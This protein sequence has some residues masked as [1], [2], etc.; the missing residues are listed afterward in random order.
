MKVNKGNVYSSVEGYTENEYIRLKKSLSFRVPNY[1][2]MTAYKR[3]GWD[4]FMC[5]LNSFTK[6]FP[7]GLIEMLPADLQAGMVIN[8]IRN[9]PLLG[10]QTGDI[11]LRGVELRDY[12][13][14]AVRACVA[15]ERAILTSPTNAGKS[16]PL[17]S[18]VFTPT[19]PKLMGDIKEGDD[20][21]TPDG[22]AAKVISI[23]PQGKL[24]VYRITFTNGDSVECSADH[25]WKVGSRVN[26][27]KEKVIPLKDIS[28]IFKN[29]LGRNTI[30]I[31]PAKNAV[32]FERRNV[33]I[34]PYLLGVLLG[35]GRLNNRVVGVSSVDG[36]ILE[37]VKS[38]L[39]PS[40]SLKPCGTGGRIDH[41]I[42]G[43]RGNKENFYIKTL[44]SYGLFDVRSHEKFIP[45]DYKYNSVDVRYAILNGLMDTDG[46][47]GKRYP[48]RGVEFCSTSKQLALDIKEIVESLGGVCRVRSRITKFTYRGIK[49][50]GKRSYTITFGGKVAARAFTLKRKLDRVS[51]GE[52]HQSWVISK[53]EPIGE[54]ECRCILVDSPDHLYLTDHCIPTHNTEMGAAIL[55]TLP[56]KA[57]WLTHRGDLLMQTRERLENRLGEPVG[58]IQ[59]ENVDLQPITIGMVQSLTVKIGK[60]CEDQEFFVDFLR[61]IDVLIIDECHHAGSGS[62]WKDIVKKCPAYYRFGLSATP[63]LRE[64]IENLWLIG[65]TGM[66]VKTVTNSDLVEQGIS[67][68]PKIRIVKN[69]VERHSIPGDYHGSY[70]QAIVNNP[71]RNACIARLAERHAA[72]KEP[73][74]ILVNTIEHGLNISSVLSCNYSF[75]TG[76]ETLEFRAETLKKMKAGKLP[77]II[78]TPI[79]DEGID[80][81]SIRVLILAAGG[82]SE[83]RMLQRVGRGMRKKKSGL[84]EVVI[85]DFEDAGDRYLRAHAVNREEICQREGFEIERIE[86]LKVGE[87]EAV[88]NGL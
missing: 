35:D 65:L 69:D 20:V 41:Y 34:D 66:E 25:L 1:W 60:E 49:K 82:K 29:K 58:V 84:N 51:V 8:D 40:Y 55:K 28:L 15:Q 14:E 59:G 68:K 85:Y 18:L 76:K 9:K 88:T 83:I 54:K 26:W 10:P 12:Q 30:Q 75:L 79:F 33:R 37:K 63:L 17:D 53:I 46:F 16:Q 81:P 6:A 23:F 5:F 2:F 13:I 67:A 42:S 7:T 22:K 74:L 43:E 73:V 44:S 78:A 61:S 80:A 19:G 70:D 77:V 32:L 56:F 27:G 64:Q 52:K 45:A 86:P 36:E 3:G 38:V 39:I 87:N 24:L 62:T 31:Y 47:A 48:R 4:G 11:K 21:S 72:A 57:L 71:E 50:D